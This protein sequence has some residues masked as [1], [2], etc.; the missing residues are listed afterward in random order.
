MTDREVPPTSARA[1]GIVE[2]R[3]GYVFT[4]RSLLERAL[5]HRSFGADHN[6]RLE[7]LGDAVLNL[8]V[9]R[10]LFDRFSGS[11]EGDLTR[12]RA[13][14]VREESLHRVAL[15]LHLPDALRMS[16]GE[17]RGGGAARPS[18]LADEVRAHTREVALVGAGKAV[19][20]QARDGEVQHCVAEELEPLVVVRAEAA[21]G[22]RTLEERTLRED[23][24]QALLHHHRGADG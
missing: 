12:V 11:D 4:Q 9:S 3:L 16:D 20:E 21:V 2:K 10:L 19:I 8:A 14:L 13:H 15:A 23:V 1:A 6:E 7:F 18:I 24:A 17:A 5:T 22:E